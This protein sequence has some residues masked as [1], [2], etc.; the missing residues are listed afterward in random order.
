MNIHGNKWRAFNFPNIGGHEQK[1]VT[2]SIDDLAL[3]QRLSFFVNT[4]RVE[5]VRV[6][7]DCCQNGS[8]SGRKLDLT[9]DEIASVVFEISRHPLEAK[10]CPEAEAER[11][12]PEE[13]EEQEP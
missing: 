4:E 10:D 6:W 8:K 7:L 2:A 9:I 11:L 13:V 5:K 12:K 3:V 1:N